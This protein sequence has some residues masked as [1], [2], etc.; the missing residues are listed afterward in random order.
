MVRHILFEKQRRL[1]SS[2]KPWKGVSRKTRVSDAAEFA[3]NEDHE[4]P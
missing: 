4:E 2:L 3:E 1:L